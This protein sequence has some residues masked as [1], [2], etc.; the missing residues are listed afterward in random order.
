MVERDTRWQPG[1]GIVRREIW[2]GKPWMGTTVLVVDDGPE[3]LASYLPPGAPFEFPDGKWPGGGR[4]P[5]HGRG[6]WEGNGVLM[7]Q[8][9][10][11][12]YAVWHF[13]HGPRRRFA[14]WYLNLQ[15]PFR[16]TSVGFDT[17]DLEL[18]IWVR[19]DGS[20]RFK[21]EEL[22]EERVRDGRFTASEI[23][24]IRADGAR[25]GAE[26]DAGRRWWS[27]DWTTWSPDPSWQPAP[28]PAGWELVD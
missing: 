6:T 12:A 7:L 18:D 13:W 28:L 2:R 5:W 15:A 24:E 16:R 17:Q 1:D 11:E 9:P 21:D 8:R 26:L 4:H 22:L 14:G 20:W 19:A 23:E 10:G 25:I 3:L 27:D